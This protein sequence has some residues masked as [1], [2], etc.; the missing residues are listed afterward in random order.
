M[1][2]FWKSFFVPIQFKY[3]NCTLVTLSL[4]SIHQ[5]LSHKI[6]RPGFSKDRY[7]IQAGT[8]GYLIKELNHDFYLVAWIGNYNTTWNGQGSAKIDI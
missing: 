4:I 8:G 3:Y 6:K 5:S 1:L 7:L 2:Q